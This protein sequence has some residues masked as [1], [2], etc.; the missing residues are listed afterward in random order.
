MATL[1]IIGLGENAPTMT[2]D[3]SVWKRVRSCKAVPKTDNFSHMDLSRTQ[4]LLD[5][6][7]VMKCT[8][9]IRSLVLEISLQSPNISP[10]ASL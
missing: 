7:S 5:A 4:L 6:Y 10:V 1:R 2:M 8:N 9:E 3:G